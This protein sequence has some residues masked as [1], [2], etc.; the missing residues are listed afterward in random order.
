MLWYAVYMCMLCDI[1]IR[2]M[3]A[4]SMDSFG[5]LFVWCG[6]CAAV[7]YCRYISN[8]YKIVT[9]YYND[10]TIMFILCYV[11][12][13]IMLQSIKIMLRMYC[14]IV[15]VLLRIEIILISFW[16]HRSRTSKCTRSILENMSRIFTWQFASLDKTWWKYV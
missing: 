11:C 13:E 10:I 3:C 14:I 12:I 8:Y 15:T 2:N 9:E 7:R 1:L 16:Y 4:C 6:R 5:F